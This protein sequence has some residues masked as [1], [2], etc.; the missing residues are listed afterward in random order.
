MQKQFALWRRGCRIPKLI[1]LDRIFDPLPEL[2]KIT[3]CVN[4]INDE[5]PDTDET[6]HC[7]IRAVWSESDFIAIGY[8]MDKWPHAILAGMEDYSPRIYKKGY[9]YMK[10]R[11]ACIDNWMISMIALDYDM[12][13]IDERKFVELSMAVD[14]NISF[15]RW[16]RVCEKYVNHYKLRRIWNKRNKMICAVRELMYEIGFIRD[17]CPVIVDYVDVWDFIPQKK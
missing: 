9:S 14:S 10:Q 11:H 12:E 7:F 16:K 5:W 17:L 6:A 8:A 2:D 15:S 3:L 13:R 4:E 1:N